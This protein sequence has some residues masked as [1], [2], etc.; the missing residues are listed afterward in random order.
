MVEGIHLVKN[1]VEGPTALPMGSFEGNRLTFFWRA[2]KSD[3]ARKVFE[4][5]MTRVLMIVIGVISSV[6]IARILG[7]EGRG[8]YAVAVSLG[9]LGVQFGNLGLH[10]S[11]TYSVAQRP[12]SLPILASN[13][14][15]VSF[16][17]GG[18]GAGLLWVILSLW[19]H[20]VQIRGTLLILALGW[21]PFG[22][23]YLL[24]QSLLVG[25]QDIRSYNLIDLGNRIL[26]LA[27]LGILL[28]LHSATVETVYVAGLITLF[29]SLLWAI[30]RLRLR[31]SSFPSPSVSLFKENLRYGMKAYVAALFAFLVLR[32]DLFIIQYMIGAE[33]A[34]FYSIAVAVADLVYMLPVVVGTILFPR[35]AG[36]TDG[37]ERWRYARI[38]VCWMAGIMVIVASLVAILAGPLV[39]LL[40]GR[41]FAP[42]IPALIWLMPGIVMLSINTI[43]MNYFASVGMPLITIYSPAVAVILNI[44]LNIRLIPPLGIVGASIASVAAYGVM[45]LASI[46]Y[47]RIKA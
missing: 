28:L 16:L 13:S 21:I 23:A 32:A 7:P 20:L 18:L 27:L 10:A 12:S 30:G 42:A 9:G 22:L 2:L 47:M 33:Q 36:M 37:Q 1:G 41:S 17:F 11:N 34:G 4:T 25:V 8:L 6:I 5:L 40:F 24:L 19:P 35:L 39:T 45:L 44:V 29:A 14:L 26:S 43:Y 38:V 31:L 15:F 3:L 46:A